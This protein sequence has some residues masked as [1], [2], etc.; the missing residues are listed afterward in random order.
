MFILV[1]HIEDVLFD[2]QARVVRNMCFGIYDF[3]LVHE[4]I[5]YK[6]S[7]GFQCCSH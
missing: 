4:S 1:S 3:Y 7:C 2:R 5:L 6:D